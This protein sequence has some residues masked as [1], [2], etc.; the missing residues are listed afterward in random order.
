MTLQDVAH[1][2]GLHVVVGN[3]GTVLT[4]PDAVTFTLRDAETSRDLEGIAFGAGL[5]VVVGDH[6]AIRNSYDA[7]DWF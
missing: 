7:I 3:D 6:Q 1:G 5:F 2:Q 4:S